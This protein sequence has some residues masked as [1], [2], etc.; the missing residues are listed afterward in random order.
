[1]VGEAVAEPGPG[2]PAALGG[3][4]RHSRDDRGAKR[5]RV[6]AMG[7]VDRDEHVP[8]SREVDAEPLNGPTVAVEMNVPVVQQRVVLGMRAAVSTRRRLASATS[9]MP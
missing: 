5:V 3:P 1:M 7:E 2:L 6:R 4:V 8:Q 9:L